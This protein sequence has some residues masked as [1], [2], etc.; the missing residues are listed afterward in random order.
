MTNYKREWP[1]QTSQNVRNL[2]LNQKPPKELLLHPR[3]MRQVLIKAVTQTTKRRCT[4]TAWNISLKRLQSSST[5]SKCQTNNNLEESPKILSHSDFRKSNSY[6]HSCNR[7]S[8]IFTLR[9][10]HGRKIPSSWHRTTRTTFATNS[11]TFKHKQPRI[12]LG[13]WPRICCINL[14]VNLWVQP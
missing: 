10:Q 4:T 2:S 1:R 14:V 11:I 12:S 5:A 3:R 13:C 6:N 7:A 9:L 8:L